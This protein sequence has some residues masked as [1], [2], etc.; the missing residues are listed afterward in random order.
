MSESLHHKLLKRQLRSASGSIEPA[1][2]GLGELLA[3]VR[4]AY[5]DADAGRA[6]IER[7]LD[8]MSRELNERHEQLRAD[9]IERRRARDELQQ[10][11]DEQ[12]ALIR[13]RQGATPQEP[14]QAA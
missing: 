14:A 1:P 7:S 2:P 3:A 4:Q 11:S 9:L 10:R 8:L 6:M 5:A 13:R 12:Q